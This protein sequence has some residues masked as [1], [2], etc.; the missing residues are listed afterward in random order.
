MKR[1][2][3]IAAVWLI[4]GLLC[5]LT[6][7]TGKASGTDG[8]TDAEPD[9]SAAVEPAAP[10]T[11]EQASSSDEGLP[12]SD[13]ADALPES[14]SAAE[15]DTAEIPS[16]EEVLWQILAPPEIALV[17]DA[18]TFQTPKGLPSEKLLTLFLAWTDYSD[19]EKCWNPKDQLFYFS[20]EVIRATLDRYFLEYNFEITECRNY[21]PDSKAVVMTNASGFGGDR[22]LRLVEK[23]V[24]GN[25]A[26]YLVD[27]AHA[28][29]EDGGYVSKIYQRKSY[30]L[31]FYD[32][33][34][35]FLSAENVDRAADEA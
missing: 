34:Y 29:Y 6:A 33:G 21:D 7:C 23:Q 24:D 10:E 20:K 17:N 19:L 4:V 28:V 11:P 9:A 22:D 13:P 25:T 32:G 18:F 31:E 16:D 26:T 8:S 12:V 30:M 15:T 27:F 1:T 5:S 3:A 35:Y 2:H 14:S